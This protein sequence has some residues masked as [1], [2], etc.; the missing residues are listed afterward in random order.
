[1]ILFSWFFETRFLHVT[2]LA[3]LELVQ[4]DLELTGLFH[5]CACTLS[6]AVHLLT[7]S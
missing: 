5:V 2:V 6:L 1:M 4:A 3:V 7:D